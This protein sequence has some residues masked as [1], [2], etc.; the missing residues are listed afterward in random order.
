MEIVRDGKEIYLYCPNGYGGTK[1]SNDFFERN[2]GI[3][4]TTKN[5]KTVKALFEIASNQSV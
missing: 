2:L 5:W 4:A 3:T 1:F